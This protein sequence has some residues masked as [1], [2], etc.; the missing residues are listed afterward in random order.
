MS[1]K[2]RQSEPLNYETKRN[3]ESIKPVLRWSLTLSAIAM[4][5][6][7]GLTFA[8]VMN[9]PLIVGY[10]FVAVAVADLAGA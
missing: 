4:L 1:N 2:H 6:F 5:A 10:V 8:G 9:F 3:P 7:A